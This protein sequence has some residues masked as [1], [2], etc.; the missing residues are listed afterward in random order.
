MALGTLS[1]TQKISISK[2]KVILIIFFDIQG[3]IHKEF[4]PPGQTVNKEHMS[5]DYLVW[6]KEFVE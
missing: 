2:N 1:K 3:I 4:V 6:F 5:K